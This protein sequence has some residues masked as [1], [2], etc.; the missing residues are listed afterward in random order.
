MPKS[1]W[2]SCPTR[3]L[4]T[5]SCALSSTKA[6][7]MLKSSAA[8]M[9]SPQAGKLANVQLQ[10]FLEPHGYHPCPITPGL[11]THTTC[12]IRFALVVNDFAICYTCQADADHLLTALKCHYQ[13]TEDWAA[14]QYCGL[15][16]TW[17]YTNCTVDLTMPGYIE[18]AFKRFQ[19][20]CPKCPE[21]SPMHGKDPPMA[22]QFNLHLTL[23]TLQP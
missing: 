8:C 9:G 5:T 18:S 17:D 1:L 12:N 16:L 21:H 10:H 11:W 23:T 7:S 14:S 13:V 6:T 3:S 20:P 22:L 19:H 4:N 2:Q 15:T